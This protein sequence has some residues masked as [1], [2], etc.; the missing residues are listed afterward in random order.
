M[1]RLKTFQGKLKKLSQKN[2]KRLRQLILDKGFCAPI[3]IWENPEGEAKTLDGHQRLTVLEQLQT[4]GYTIPPLPVAIIYADSEK[5]A[6]EKLLS[7]SSQFGEW[8]LDELNVWLEDVDQ[9][10]IGN[11]RIADREI[12][13]NI[14]NTSND[15]TDLS[16]TYNETYEIVVKLQ[17]ESEQQKLFER[18]TREGYKC[19]I[20]TL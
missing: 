13:I 11:L 5:D 4:D 2:H 18:L 6:R 16:D 15:E 8:N 17:T 12:D 7:I 19:T 3:F 1:N 20:S 10:I 9:I 14:N